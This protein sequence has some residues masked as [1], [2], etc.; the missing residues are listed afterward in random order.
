MFHFLLTIANRGTLAQS[1][2]EQKQHTQGSGA[3]YSAANASAAAPSGRD[4]ADGAGSVTVSRW[5]RSTSVDFIRQ[6]SPHPGN[7]QSR[8]LTGHFLAVMSAAP[9]SLI[10][11]VFNR[12]IPLNIARSPAHATGYLTVGVSGILVAWIRKLLYTALNGVHTATR[13]CAILTSLA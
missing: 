1:L 13:Q 8:P 5:G 12:L 6:P 11:H 9:A 7:R 4:S 3:A 2:S 10:S